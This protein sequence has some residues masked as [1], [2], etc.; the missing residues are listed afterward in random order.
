M[1]KIEIHPKLGCLGC[2]ILNGDMSLDH[3]DCKTVK[4]PDFEWCSQ[5]V[6]TVVW[7]IVFEGKYNLV[8]CLF[9]SFAIVVSNPNILTAALAKL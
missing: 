2:S 8:A 7:C 1:P 9:C 3:E 6:N 4:F 5:S